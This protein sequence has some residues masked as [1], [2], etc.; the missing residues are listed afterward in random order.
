MKNIIII[1][2]SFFSIDD[3]HEFKIGRYEVRPNQDDITLF[4]ALDRHDFTEVVQKQS[5]CSDSEAFATCMTEYIVDHFKLNFDGVEACMEYQNH[6]VKKELIEMTFRIGIN[7]EE[8]NSIK[9]FND[10][11][12]EQW[13]YQENIMFFL[14]NDKQRSFRLNKN[15]IRTQVD[16]D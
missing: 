16:Y 13:S 7:P 5:G 11:L 10:I 14:L 3:F 4:I 12:L 9:V 6:T 1:L 15:R 8:V 2:A